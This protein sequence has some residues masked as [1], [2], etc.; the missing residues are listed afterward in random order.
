[1]DFAIFPV[2]FYLR[3]FVYQLYKVLE[4]IKINQKVELTIFINNI[5]VLIIYLFL[6]YICFN[7]KITHRLKKWHRTCTQYSTH[8]TLT[9]YS[10]LLLCLLVFLMIGHFNRCKWCNNSKYNSMMSKTNYK[11][12]TLFRIVLLDKHLATLVQ[13]LVW[14]IS[15]KSM[16]FNLFKI[17]KL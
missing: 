9:F 16:E 2:C 11:C 14:K 12:Q 8:T 6:I 5:K 7:K 3:A 13:E 10:Q 15:W 4:H 1:M 17:C